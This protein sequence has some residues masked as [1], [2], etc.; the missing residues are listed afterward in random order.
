M[1][2]LL[3]GIFFTYP[4]HS[5]ATTCQELFPQHNGGQPHYYVYRYCQGIYEALVTPNDQA[6]RLS[7]FP[8]E[9]LR[10]LNSQPSEE[11]SPIAEALLFLMRHR[12]CRIPEQQHTG[13]LEHVSYCNA[14]LVA[15]HNE[16]CSTLT[17]TH[18]GVE[19]EFAFYTTQKM[20]AVCEGAKLGEFRKKIATL[21]PPP[22]LTEL[23]ARKLTPEQIPKLPL[24][25]LKRWRDFL[26]PAAQQALDTRIA[27]ENKS[28]KQRGSKAEI[29]K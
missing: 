7:A 14:F 21:P 28:K 18:P 19:V 10:A 27:N 3:L 1:R 23:S 24:F 2:F 20:R 29:G 13:L 15:L 12:H 25:E 9:I 11:E 22:S 8:R 26:S 6:Q 4:L 17:Y 5:F 16:D